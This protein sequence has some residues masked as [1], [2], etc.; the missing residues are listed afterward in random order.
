MLCRKEG[1]IAETLNISRVMTILT[2][3]LLEEL[4]LVKDSYCLCTCA[5]LAE[6]HINITEFVQGSLNESP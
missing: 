3:H 4:N 1:H 2:C 6:S 5:V